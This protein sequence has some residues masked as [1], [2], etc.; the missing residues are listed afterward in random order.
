MP[1]SQQELYASIQAM[2]D[3]PAS[4]YAEELSEDDIPSIDFLLAAHARKADFTVLNRE[5]YGY[6]TG[7]QQ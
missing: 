7:K 5:D 3:D 4:Q 6:L 2:L 1:I